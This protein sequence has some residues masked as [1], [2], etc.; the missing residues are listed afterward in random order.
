M[1]AAMPRQIQVVS[2]FALSKP[3]Q[4]LLDRHLGPVDRLGAA[5]RFRVLRVAQTLADLAGVEAVSEEQI[6]EALLLG[7][8][9]RG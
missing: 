8:G 6:L 9:K 4:D 1:V 3:A 7:G 2:Q 5:R